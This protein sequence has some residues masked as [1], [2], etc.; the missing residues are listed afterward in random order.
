MDVLVQSEIKVC[1]EIYLPVSFC[2]MTNAPGPI[3]KIYSHPQG[4]LPNSK[5]KKK[6]YNKLKKI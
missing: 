1:G 5:K 3:T 6:K 2:F 4:K